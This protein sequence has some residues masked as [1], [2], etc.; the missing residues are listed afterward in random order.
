[1]SQVIFLMGPTASG[2]TALA[3]E[4][5]K[6][7]PIDLISVDSAMIY[8]GMDIGTAKPEPDILREFPHKLI[9]IKDP[10]EPYSVADFYKDARAEIE[11]SLT[12]GRIPLLVGGTMLYFNAL[13]KGL[14]E[15]PEADQY[16]RERIATEAEELG[17]PALHVKLQKIDPEAAI[18]IKPTDS[19]RISRALEVYEQTGQPLSSLWVPG[20]EPLPY[21][22]TALAIAPQDRKILHERI[23]QRFKLM[24]EQGFID[25]VK[26]LK[27]RGDLHEKL[28]SIRCVGYR[29]IWQY[30]NGELSLEVAMEKAIVATRQLA[31][32]QFTWLR[33][34]PELIWLDSDSPEA[35]RIA[36]SYI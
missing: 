2:K 29:Q 3:I 23:A 12:K 5:A 6:Q 35:L 9:N 1:V 20:L 26:K 15:L 33:S 11:V 25:E 16:I 21:K 28:P 17:W 4:L 32:R 18:K 24:L 27:D 31:K 34:W 10:S 8:K 14:S 22:I 19:Q 36:T 7:H 30:L 13:R